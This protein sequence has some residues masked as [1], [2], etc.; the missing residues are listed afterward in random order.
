MIDPYFISLTETVKM[1]E[2]VI[3][4]DN[5]KLVSTQQDREMKRLLTFSDDELALAKMVLELVQTIL[6]FPYNIS[7][8]Q[9]DTEYYSGAQCVI[10]FSDSVSNKILKTDFYDSLFLLAERFIIEL[11]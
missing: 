2:L 11:P 7:Y 4:Q 9:Y 1:N 5:L 8:A 6:D 3:L 10:Y